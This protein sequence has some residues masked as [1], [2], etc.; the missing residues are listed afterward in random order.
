MS[1]N[2]VGIRPNSEISVRLCPLCHR[3]SSELLLNGAIGAELE[4]ANSKG[5]PKLMI[6]APW[7]LH[8]RMWYFL[9]SVSTKILV[10]FFYSKTL[11]Q[12]CMIT[13]VDPGS[14]S[15]STILKVVY[16]GGHWTLTAGHK[17]AIFHLCKRRLSIFI[18]NSRILK[19]ITSGRCNSLLEKQLQGFVQECTCWKLVDASQPKC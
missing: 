13:I 10:L 14:R 1:Q 5:C 16:F 17:Y 19:Q 9:L 18:P 11:S 6:A 12:S 4:K 3:G 15:T 8:E 2:C 7:P